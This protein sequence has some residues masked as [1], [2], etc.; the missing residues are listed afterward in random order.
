LQVSRGRRTVAG[1]VWM[2]A[3]FALTATM[4]SGCG[5]NGGS[6]STTGQ[7]GTTNVL[8]TA[9]SGTVTKSIPLTVNFQ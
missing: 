6:G 7:T 5:G 3:V 2:L 1:V 8:V 4:L 9:T